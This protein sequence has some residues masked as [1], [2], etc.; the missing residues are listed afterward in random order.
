MLAAVALLLSGCTA[1]ST[2]DDGGSPRR[3]L[4]ATPQSLPPAPDPVLTPSA[5]AAGR[6]GATATAGASGTTRPGAPGS[7]PPTA[8]AGSSAAAPPGG[9]TQQPGAPGGTYRTVGSATDR[10][11][12]A[13]AA[14]PAY[15]D[16][17][18]VTVEDDGTNVRITVRFAGDVPARLPADETMGV[19]VDLY[20]SAAQIESDYQ[21]FADGQPEGWYAYLQTPK[22]FVKYPG[23]FG[24][25]GNRL[26]FTVPWSAVGSPS[27]GAFSAFADWTRD[28]TPV[29]L[30]GEDV[31]PDLGN[32]AYRR[33]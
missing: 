19:G 15:G 30:A 16:L 26:V 23:T 17:R 13:G 20:R 21:V 33:S 24:V 18:S 31:A 32:A 22:G 10:D 7:A 5:S 29:N 9:S 8:P 4:A 3:D 11:R 6:P 2:E 1:G 12:D 28:A 14:T 27:A 25:G